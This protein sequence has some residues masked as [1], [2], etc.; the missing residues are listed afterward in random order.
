[1]FELIFSAIASVILLP[2]ILIIATPF[3]LVFGLFE[4]ENYLK[5]V[6]EKY[7][8]VIRWWDKYIMFIV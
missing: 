8:K 7:K 2:I 6:K 3:I 5:N 4:K 1:M